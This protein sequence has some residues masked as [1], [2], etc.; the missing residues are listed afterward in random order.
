VDLTVGDHEFK[1]GK[2]LAGGRHEGLLVEEQAV[3]KLS[4]I[5][6]EKQRITF[7]QDWRMD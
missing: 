7:S 3:L 5:P 6:L 2:V 1:T 4:V